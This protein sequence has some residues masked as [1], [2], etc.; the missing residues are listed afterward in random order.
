LEPSLP[1]MLDVQPTWK[2]SANANT[3]V[4]ANALTL[5][6]WTTIDPQ[7]AGMW[8]QVELPQPANLVEIQ[9]DSATTG[10]GGG[11]G[12]RGGAGGPAAA[13][14]PQTPGAAPPP[15]PPSPIG[16]PRQYQVQLSM[17]GTKWSTPPVATGT[18]SSART[19]IAFKA[20]PAR[21]V[22][23][24]QTGSVDNA[25]AWSIMNLRLYE[26][27]AATGGK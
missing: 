25:P 2:A 24:T 14:G 13:P 4:A 26:A 6:G 10:R 20:A 18:G 3:S 16:F 5:A 1:H 9:F 23:I 21:F 11:A 27:G 22:R 7:K 15:A 17:D 12:A 19:N 8:F